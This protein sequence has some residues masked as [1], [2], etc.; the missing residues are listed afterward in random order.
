MRRTNRPIAALA[1]LLVAGACGTADS[2]LAPDATLSP[3][4]PPSLNGGYATGG[5]RAES[6]TTTAT[7][8]STTTQTDTTSRT[9]GY[10]T[11]G[12]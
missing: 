8:T 6:D 7:T 11:G 1:V 9:G 4:A 5:N 3:T 10:A 12:N 2:P